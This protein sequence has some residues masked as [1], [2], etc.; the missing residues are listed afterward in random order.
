MSACTPEYQRLGQLADTVPRA[1]GPSCQW[2][3]IG[4][5]LHLHSTRQ[6]RRQVEYSV[7]APLTHRTGRCGIGRLLG[8]LLEAAVAGV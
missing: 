5:S 8:I 7:Y 4:N 2:S 3:S 1:V 6:C